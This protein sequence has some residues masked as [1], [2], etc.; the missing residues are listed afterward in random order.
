MP[1]GTRYGVVSD[2]WA[3]A[4]A[5]IIPRTAPAAQTP[6]QVA[7]KNPMAVQRSAQDVPDTP[8]SR[9]RCAACND[10]VTGRIA[11]ERCPTCGGSVWGYEGWPAWGPGNDGSS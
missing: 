4:G 5:P 3:G 8:P 9:F 6:R 1:G 2:V 10:L 7:P 11:P